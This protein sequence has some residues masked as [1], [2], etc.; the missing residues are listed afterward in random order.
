MNR[1]F[2]SQ[3]AKDVFNV[4]DVKRYVLRTFPKTEFYDNMNYVQEKTHEASPFSPPCQQRISKKTLFF[5]SHPQ[6]YLHKVHVLLRARWP[7]VQFHREGQLPKLSPALAAPGK[8][9]PETVEKIDDRMR[10]SFWRIC[11]QDRE[12]LICETKI[13]NG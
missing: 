3:T 2:N 12:L 8:K 11:N 4:K 13:Y 1:G 7:P 6:E 9:I 5:V 10:K